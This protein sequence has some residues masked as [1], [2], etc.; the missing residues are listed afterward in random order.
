MTFPTDMITTEWE[1]LAENDAIDLI[2]SRLKWEPHESEHRLRICTSNNL[3]CIFEI[4]V[5]EG[6]SNEGPEDRELKLLSVCKIDNQHTDVIRQ[7]SPHFY[8]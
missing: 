8:H 7:D 5:K 1:G 6:H 4:V 3:D 2:F